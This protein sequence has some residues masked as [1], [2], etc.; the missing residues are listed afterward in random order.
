M[1]EA[2]PTLS[3]YAFVARTKT[4]LAFTSINIQLPY[5]IATSDAGF[6]L[7]SLDFSCG[8][9]KVRSLVEKE[10][11]VQVSLSVRSV[12]II[13]PL[14]QFYILWCSETD[15]ATAAFNDPIVREF[16]QCKYTMT[17]DRGKP[18]CL[19]K[20]CSGLNFATTYPTRII[21]GLNQDFCCKK[22]FLHIYLS[23]SPERRESPHQAK[24]ET[25]TTCW[26]Q[27]TEVK[28]WGHH[29]SVQS[30]C[31]KRTQWGIPSQIYIHPQ[32]ATQKHTD[33]EHSWQRVSTVGFLKYRKLPED[34]LI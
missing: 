4:T 2:I 20:T 29:V 10:A 6:S 27:C 30:L 32:P 12:S 23:A 21:L 24:H 31:E 7:S 15:S 13:P 33:H 26:L 17:T 1:S 34:G 22:P 5:Q 11:L 9:L 8:W 16:L 14:L 18:Q 3:P 28:F 19:I 25:S